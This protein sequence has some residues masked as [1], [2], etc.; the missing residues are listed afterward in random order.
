M[1]HSDLQL[2]WLP[3]WDISLCI[4]VKAAGFWSGVEM[5]GGRGELPASQRVGHRLS[6]LAPCMC[7]HVTPAS[8]FPVPVAATSL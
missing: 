8:I 3:C 1:H 6:H 4:A 7:C 5:G 2:I